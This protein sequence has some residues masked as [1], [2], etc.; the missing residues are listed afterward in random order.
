MLLA[1]TATISFAA[2]FSI[3]FRAVDSHGMIDTVWFGV[4]QNA[5]TCVDVALGEYQ[6]PPPPPSFDIRFVNYRAGLGTCLGTGVKIDLRGY[7]SPTQVD[8]Y[9]V[10]FSTGAGYDI[11]PITFSWP[12]LNTYYVN[13]VWLQDRYGTVFKLDMKT[14]T[15]FVLTES[16]NVFSLLIVTGD[17]GTAPSQPTAAPTINAINAIFIGPS[18]APLDV[19]S[20]PNGLPT[21]VWFES[22]TTTAYGNAT[23]HR[24]IGSGFDDISLSD[25]LG[26]LSPLTTYHYRAVAQND[27]GTVY[28]NDATF[29]TMA[30]NDGPGRIV[31]PITAHDNVGM[32]GIAYFGLYPGATY[33]IDPDLGETQPYP[34][35]PPAFDIRMIPGFSIN[36]CLDLGVFADIR[37]YVSTSQGE[38]FIVR[39][40]TSPDVG[41]PMTLSWPD[42]NLYFNQP[43][44]L[45]DTRGGSIVDIDMKAQN[46]ISISEEMGVYSLFI[47]I[48]DGTHVLTAPNINTAG[49]LSNSVTQTSA[50][51]VGSVIPN[52]DSTTAWFE[53]GATT[54]YGNTS[55]HF[56]LGDGITTIMINQ[57]ISGLTPRTT[58]HCRVVAEN[59][60]GTTYGSDWTFTT[61]LDGT[62]GQ[63]LLPLSV[64]D[65][66]SISRT[67]WLGADSQATSCVDASLG[68]VQLP[69]VP[70]GFDVRSIGFPGHT[71]LSLGVNMDFRKLDSP[72]QVDTYKIRLST[73][74][75]K[76]PLTITWPDLNAWFNGAV[77]M[78]DVHG[79]LGVNVDMK[80]Q[81]SF[82]LPESL[83]IVAVYIVT[84]TPASSPQAPAVLT[85]KASAIQAA[86][87][88]YNALLNPNGY[89][90][91]RWFEWGTTTDYGHSTNPKSVD[92]TT[93]IIP[94]SETITGLSTSTTYH[95]RAVAQNI[96]GTTYGPDKTFTTTLVTLV[97]DQKHIPT[98]FT[99]YQNYPNPFNPTTT[100][101]LVIGHSSFVSLKVY[102]VLGR[103]IATIVNEQLPP[104][105]YTRTWSAEGIPSGVYTYRLVAETFVSVKKMVVM[106]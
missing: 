41:Y 46:S 84:G 11:Y 79:G 76:Y 102:D 100:M 35:V 88:Q 63:N 74:I 18:V 9:R 32:S 12:D 39:F 36:H 13:H 95:Y 43:V 44:R 58:Y 83:G 8:T 22:G 97:E 30:G 75:E 82:V 70:P 34:P 40:Q 57:S 6:L 24:S 28:S 45:T 78:V 80:Q 73:E 99:L 14:Q 27:K 1:F 29:K 7:Y 21:N 19:S 55:T 2:D 93:G 33:C 15:S 77:Q 104:G 64:S 86:S 26:G 65:A 56:S 61:M 60:L 42:L 51:L 91:S 25:T 90:A 54:S 69:P 87:A 106:R 52:G 59:S 67:F 48:G 94:E 20:N 3:P 105:A 62:I 17:S 16:L 47:K 10:N 68:E 38:T 23:P 66:T 96:N 50:D 5:T 4:N 98:V 71:C 53:W 89:Q 92:G 31:I 85:T 81:N 103:E 72:T 101:S 49:A 37:P